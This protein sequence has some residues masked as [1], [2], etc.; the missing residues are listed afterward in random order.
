MHPGHSLTNILLLVVTALLWWCGAF[1]L[2]LKNG[3]PTVDV[4]GYSLF[5]A[6]NCTMM[7]FRRFTFWT[8]LGMAIGWGG[9]WLIL[10]EY[11]FSMSDRL[12]AIWYATRI[13]FGGVTLMAISAVTGGAVS[14]VIAGNMSAAKGQ[15]NQ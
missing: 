14:L 15:Q 1:V 2:Y 5:L 8:V 3:V 12:S 6:V 4:F 9:C 13:G 7:Y 11:S 10:P